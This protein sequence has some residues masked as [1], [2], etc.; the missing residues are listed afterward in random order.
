MTLAQATVVEAFR[1]Q[2]RR[3]PEA[4]ALRGSFAPITF[5]AL[6][7]RVDALGESL[8]E[9]GIGPGNRVAI[10]LERSPELIVAMLGVLASGAA[11]VPL[12]PA[13]PVA[14]NRAMLDDCTPALLLG[15]FEYPIPA[16]PP[17]RWP[18]TP[19]TPSRQSEPVI[20]QH[21]AAYIIY[22]SG[23]T[24]TPKGVVVEHGALAN[25][26]AWCGEAAPRT[27]GGAPLFATVA[28]DHAITCLF[29]PLLAGEPITLLPSI[30]GGRTLA[31]SLLTGHR[32]SFVKITPSHLLLLTADQQAALGRS[33]DLVMLG[34]EASSGEL[35]ARLR[36]D[37]PGLPVMN[38]YGPTEATVGCCVFDV[39]P[40]TGA[41]SLPIGFPIPGVVTRITNDGE[42]LIGGACLARGYWRRPDL[43]EAAFITIDDERWYR[44]GDLVRERTDG[45]L[46]YLGRIDGQ[47]KMLGHRIE[48]GEIEAALRSYPGVADAAVIADDGRLIAAVV[49]PV[50]ERAFRDALTSRL[51]AAM[52]PARFVMLDALP[53][54]INGK[55]DRK[56]LLDRLQEP[57]RVP[58]IETAL[59]RK[60][61]ETLGLAEIGLDDDFFELGGDSLA[62]VEIVTWAETAFGVELEL[63]ALFEHSTVRSLA[64]AIRESSSS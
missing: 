31:G 49:P 30:D 32:Y 60:W 51:P 48:P 12:D 8:H 33:A 59:L 52:I 14:R 17:E 13:Y 28:F 57:A 62:S 55:L 36:R 35:V 26:L 58:D 23:S 16:L 24:G 4:I 45:S 3:H 63:A 15:A 18:S 54:T 43:D 53:V 9:R 47:I 64:A 1:A 56:A 22:T 37:N 39:P 11:Y 50:D 20:G 40:D 6:L 21:D 27:G 46:D 10:C 5:G 29:P 41:G 25:Y 2:A 38:H 44:S 61:R 42:L 19:S 34:G 7:E